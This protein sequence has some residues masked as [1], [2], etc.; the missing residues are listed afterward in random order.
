MS[1]S[2][3][4]DRPVTSGGASSPL[5]SDASCARQPEAS[6]PS[7]GAACSEGVEDSQLRPQATSDETIVCTRSELRQILIE[8]SM[9]ALTFLLGDDSPCLEPLRGQ[10]VGGVL[11]RLR[12]LMEATSP[13]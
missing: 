2:G 7:A 1:T 6:S 11:L 9:E 5:S 10:I 12:R 8:E 3:Q 13:E 4:R